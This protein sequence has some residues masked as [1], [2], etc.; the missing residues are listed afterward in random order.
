MFLRTSD[1]G[2]DDSA[3]PGATHVCLQVATPLA[4][5]MESQHGAWVYISGGVKV[6]LITYRVELFVARSLVPLGGATCTASF[7]RPNPSFEKQHP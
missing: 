5:A 3:V 1:I 7:D 4:P 2:T 6:S